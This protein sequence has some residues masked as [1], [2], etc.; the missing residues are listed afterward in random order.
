[1]G[2]NYSK[3]A[4]WIITE[5]S[6]NPETLGKCEAIMS[7]GNGYLGLRSA[8]EEHYLHETRGMFISG[9]FNKFDEDVI[10]SFCL[11]QTVIMYFRRMTAT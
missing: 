9:T 8:T 5:D 3:I 11:C 1:M 4:D 6:F 7:L 10:K 2:I